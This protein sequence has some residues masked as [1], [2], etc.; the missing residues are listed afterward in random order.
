MIHL[1]FYSMFENRPYKCEHES[2]ECMVKI[3]IPAEDSTHIMEDVHIDRCILA[4]LQD[5]WANGIKTL[6]S[7]CGHGAPFNAFITV[8]RSCKEQMDAMGYESP[9]DLLEVC[10][11]CDE[12]IMYVPKSILEKTPWLK[13]ELT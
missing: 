6:C 4:E 3:S 1:S 12:G 2:E 9:P 7:C 5:L 11:S 8:D 10:G 13:T